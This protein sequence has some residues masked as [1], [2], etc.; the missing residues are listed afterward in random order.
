[1]LQFF[2]IKTNFNIHRLSNEL[3]QHIA[4]EIVKTFPTEV[5]T[6]YYLPPIK[7]KDSI[8]NKSK[9]SRGKLMSMWRNYTYKNKVLEKKIKKEEE[10]VNNET[11]NEE[12]GEK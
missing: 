10:K 3:A 5:S 9:S 2:Q 6:T 12:A 11:D 1:M 8:E 7:K 4:N